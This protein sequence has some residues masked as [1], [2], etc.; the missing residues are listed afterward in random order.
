[1][2]PE[3]F[4][5]T[6]QELIKLLKTLFLMMVVAP[7]SLIFIIIV[8][9]I[10]AVRTHE[11]FQDALF[12]ANSTKIKVGMTSTEV[13]AMLL[14]PDAIGLNK[15]DYS[16][17]LPQTQFLSQFQVDHYYSPES[18]GEEV[19]VYNNPDRGGEHDLKVVFNLKTKKVVQLGETYTEDS[20]LF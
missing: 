17:R 11:A 5:T 9:R 2:Q 13:E 12:R 4:N 16:I 3:S 15:G 1:M 20:D 10:V 8:G 6:T 19:W 18:S 7:I 14:W